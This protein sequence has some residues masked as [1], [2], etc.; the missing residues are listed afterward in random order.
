MCV[1]LCVICKIDRYLQT[2]IFHLAVRDK[3][4]T[5]KA[6]LS[7]LFFILVPVTVGC[8]EGQEIYVYTSAWASGKGTVR[9][10]DF[11]HRQVVLR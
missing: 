9:Q 4:V 7:S 2:E 10:T 8:Q 11:Y 5:L 6:S 3:T 1:S